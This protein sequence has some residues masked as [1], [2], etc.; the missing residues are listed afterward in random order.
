MNFLKLDNRLIDCLPLESITPYAVEP[1]ASYR[2]YA[3]TLEK[4]ANIGEIMLHRPLHM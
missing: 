4:P 2:P 1:A 3:R